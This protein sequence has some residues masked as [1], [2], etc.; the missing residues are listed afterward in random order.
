MSK[1]LSPELLT[2]SNGLPVIFQNNDAPVAS[3]Y[4]WNQVGSADEY[5]KEAGFAHFLE[6]MHF[7]DTDAKSSGRASSGELARAIESF[8]GDVN[9]YTSFDQTVYHVTCAAHHWEKVL[10]V[11]GTMGK[12]QRFLKEDFTRERE[13]IL[14]ELKKNEDAPGRKLFQSLF[15]ATFAK[16]PYGRPVIG[17]A[18]TLKAAKVAD[19]EAFYR[20][21]YVSG[22]M[23][24]VLVGP[25]DEKRKKA[26]VA[27][28][29]SLFGGKILKKKPAVHMKRVKESETRAKATFEKVPFDVTTPTLAFSFRVPDLMHEDMPALDML[30]GILGMG[31]MCRLYQALFYGKSI[32][33]DVGGGLYVPKDPGMI[34]FNADVETVEKLPEVFSSMLDEILRIQ[35]D[36]PTEEE[37]ARILTNTESERYYALQSADGIASRLGFLRFQL[38]DLE[39]DDRY[40]AEL[41][42]V[43]AAKIQAAAAKYFDLSRLAFTVMVPEKDKDFDLKPMFEIAQSKLGRSAIEDEGK[44]AVLKARSAKTGKAV[45]PTRAL[46]ELITLPSGVRVLYRERPNSHVMSIQAAV[47]GGLR[48]EVADPVKSPD[49]DLG[50]SNLLSSVWAK[51]TTKKS[52]QTITSLVEGA[53]ANLDGFSGRNTI[54]LASTGLARDW[55]KLSDLFAEVLVHPSFPK[56]ELDLSRKVVEDSIRSIEDHSSALCSKLFHETLF[57]RHPYGRFASGTLE[58]VAS[59]DSDRLRAFHRKW[60]RPDRLVLSVVGNVPRRELDAWL[61]NLDAELAAMKGEHVKGLESIGDEPALKGPRWVDRSL[62]REQVH[63]IVGGLGLR[64]GDAERYAMRLATNVLGGQSGRLFIELREKRSMA[65]TVSPISMEGIER[66]YIGTYIGCSPSKKDEAIAGIA[67]VLEDLAKKGPSAAEMRRAKEYYLGRRAMDLQGDSS[68]AGYY[69]L[70]TV[71]DLPIR[72]E[73]EIVKSIESVS[74]KQVQEFVRKYF[75]ENNAVTSVVG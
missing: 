28:L 41:R 73:A 58:S 48:L 70:E 46:P 21:M 74:A 53:A 67:K 62:G 27:I 43:D 68:L 5:P 15:T 47:L 2:L 16:H 32:V 71:Y 17:Y 66:G 65:Y 57:E 64:F 3:I 52:A 37:I 30:G 29:E 8:G 75:V 1:L 50:T 35:T 63:I 13:V 38:G 72:T 24:L 44:A 49:L 40:L 61:A 42:K 7:K 34:Y 23:G 25:F 18:K 56:E 39:Y 20:R 31:E 19:L 9:A 59:I 69:A 26:L 60:L 54:G 36:A 14:E 33:N 45:D 22:N 11:F 51:G 4:W 55:R 10:R 12:P 6:H